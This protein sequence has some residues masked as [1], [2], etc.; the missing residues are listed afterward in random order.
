M[1]TTLPDWAIPGVKLPPRGVLAAW[2]ARAT[3]SAGSWSIPENRQDMRGGKAY[4][5]VLARRLN[6]GALR[7]AAH[8]ERSCHQN[9]SHPMGAVVCVV[10]RPELVVY[11]RTLGG[12]VY[13]LAV[14]R[15]RNKA[16]TKKLG[17]KRP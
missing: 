14:L 7:E 11:T 10:E 15:Q 2:G 17:R 8:T 4:R 9:R 6:A 13:V 1:T 12:Y 3:A 5:D 16:T